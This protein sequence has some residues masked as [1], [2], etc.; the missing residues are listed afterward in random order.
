MVCL[1]NICR[2]PLAE[3]LLQSKLPKHGFRVDSAGLIDFHEGN[4]PHKDSIKIALQNH[5]DISKQKSRPILSKDFEEFD[6]IYAMDQSIAKE[7]IERSSSQFH[8][9]IKLILSESNTTNLDVKDPYGLDFKEFEAMYRLLDDVTD[10]VAQ[11][12][13]K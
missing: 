2:S 13:L 12:L 6:V 4:A 8:H 10:S 9:K 7:L 11:K 1:G 5:I 3:G